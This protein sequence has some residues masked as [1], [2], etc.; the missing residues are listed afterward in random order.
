MKLRIICCYQNRE[1]DCRTTCKTAVLGC[2][3]ADLMGKTAHLVV[4]KH[5]AHFKAELSQSDR[6]LGG[7]V[8]SQFLDYLAQCGFT[9]IDD[10]FVDIVVDG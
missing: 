5:W 9:V 10:D 1:H 8:F 4:A 2:V 3:Q 6:E 7:Q